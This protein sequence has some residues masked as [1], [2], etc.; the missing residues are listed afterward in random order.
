MCATLATTIYAVI[1]KKDINGSDKL[2]LTR[3]SHVSARRAKKGHTKVEMASR[4]EP[5]LAPSLSAHVAPSLSRQSAG[6][7]SL[8][9]S[10][11]FA[12]QIALPFLSFIR[13]WFECF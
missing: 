10:L 13:F 7:L 1:E 2:R 8:S 6:L 11:S 5:A 12:T 3:Q 4:A 9:L